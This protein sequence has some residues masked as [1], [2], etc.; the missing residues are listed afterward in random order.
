MNASL[1]VFQI[2]LLILL[3]LCNISPIRLSS[4]TF[5]KD[6]LNRNK[7]LIPYDK[8]LPVIPELRTA[9]SSGELC[10]KTTDQRVIVS[11]CN[12]PTVEPLWNSPADWQ[13][14]QAFFSDLNLDN[15]RELAL[16]VWRPFKPW[17]VD[18]FLPSGGRITTFHDED[19]R[20]CHLI[21]INVIDGSFR[22]IWAGSAMAA[23]IHSMVAADLDGDG[24]Q[25]L[26][27]VEYPYNGK[28]RTGTLVV[29]R[30]NGF[31]FSLEARQAGTFSSLLAT[32]SG[33]KVMLLAQ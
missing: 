24:R 1:S 19:D 8:V 15:E 22:E 6:G 16:L 30:W 32:Q 28:K 23:P 27:A 31:G 25:E 2:I 18:R 11:M 9:R 20:S 14:E 3:A 5:T 12:S 13:V 26:A 29:W 21:L 33:K 10:L 4:W 17:P 7:T